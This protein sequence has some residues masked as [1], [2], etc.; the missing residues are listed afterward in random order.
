MQDIFVSSLCGLLVVRLPLTFDLKVAPAI[1]DPH[2]KL[3]PNFNFTRI[4][5]D[6]AFD[7]AICP[8]TSPDARSA[9]PHQRSGT[10]SLLKSLPATQKQLSINT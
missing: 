7:A 1:F 9:M 6:F 5:F 8:P 4:S 3:S 10:V 2:G